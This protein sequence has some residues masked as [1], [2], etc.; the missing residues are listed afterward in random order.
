MVFC[1]FVLSVTDLTMETAQGLCGS[2]V[3]RCWEIPENRRVSAKLSP[4]PSALSSLLMRTLQIDWG[5]SN[6]KR[7]EPCWCLSGDKS[8][9]LGNKPGFP[10]GA[11]C[12]LCYFRARGDFIG[13]DY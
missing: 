5:V 7:T 11:A 9:V 12:R 13:S 4:D 6:L 1:L 3:L 8:T 2:T 10:F